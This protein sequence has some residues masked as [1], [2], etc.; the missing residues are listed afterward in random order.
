M[1]VYIYMFYMYLF[2]SNIY[3]YSM[4]RLIAVRICLFFPFFALFHSVLCIYNHELAIYIY[5][6]FFR[7]TVNGDHADVLPPRSCQSRS[8]S[9]HWRRFLKW[10]I[11]DNKRATRHAFI[12][13]RRKK[14]NYS[15][16]AIVC[17]VLNRPSLPSACQPQYILFLHAAK[18]QKSDF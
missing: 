5:L 17:C 6:F 1:R 10:L 15:L 11:G 13:N 9:R 12:N 3:L 16:T 4:F 7:A 8:C 14:E 18:C 2:P